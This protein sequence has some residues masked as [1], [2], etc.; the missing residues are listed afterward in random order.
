MSRFDHYDCSLGCP[1]EATLELI[2]G[3]WK[4]V[5]LYHLIDGTMRF[6][7]LH[8]AA[9]TVTQRVLTKALR[10]LEAAGLVSRT[11]HPV[12][13][14]HVDYALTEKGRTLVPLLLAMR[15]WGLEHALPAPPSTLNENILA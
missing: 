9:G 6:N 13:P 11:V 4:G 8:R 15:D 2:G 12:V 14:P 3:K 5:V 1:V 7:E 10:E